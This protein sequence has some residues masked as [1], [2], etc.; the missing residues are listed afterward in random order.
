MCMA[1]FADAQRLVTGSWDGM[2][3]MLKGGIVEDPNISAEQGLGWYSKSTCFRAQPCMLQMAGRLSS[4]RDSGVG[5][6]NRRGNL[7][8][9]V[10]EL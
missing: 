4:G 2:V 10:S 5:C 7:L 8:F 9:D 1:F 6:V 3:R